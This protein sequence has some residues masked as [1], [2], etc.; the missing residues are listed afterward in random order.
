VVIVLQ[1]YQSARSLSAVVLGFA[2]V[3]VGVQHFTDPDYFTPIVPA[4]LGFPDFWVYVSGAVEV[5][6]GFGL[7]LPVS[8]RRAGFSTAI[9]LV[10][11]YWAN[12]NMWMNDIAVGDTKLNTTGHIVRGCIQIGM[13]WLSLWIAEWPLRKEK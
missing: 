4:I 3:W 13:I 2:F 12:L 11:I 8:R 7:I 10:F 9:F 5:I 6:L 1:A